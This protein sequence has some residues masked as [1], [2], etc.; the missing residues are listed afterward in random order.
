MMLRSFRPIVGV[1]FVLLSNMG[2]SSEKPSVT[3][4]PTILIIKKITIDV[5]GKM[6]DLFKIEQPD[7]TSHRRRVCSM[8]KKRI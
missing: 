3:V 2:F 6:T 7:G 8:V 5:D 4:K 1:L